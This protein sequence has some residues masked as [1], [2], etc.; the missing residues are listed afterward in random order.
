MKVLLY[1]EAENLIKESGLGRAIEHQKLALKSAKVSYTTDPNDSYDLAHINTY[2]LNSIRI[3][4]LCKREGKPVV[5][6]AHSTKEDFE[7]SFIGSN[8]A[9]PFFKEWLKYAYQ[10]G[11]II[12]TPSAYS[13][14]LL[15]SYHIKKEIKVVSNGIDLNHYQRSLIDP[16]AFRQKYGLT[17][18]QPVVVSVGLWI[19]RKGILDFLA[20][21]KRMPEITFFWFGRTEEQLV[22]F[23]IREAIKH[24]PANVVMPGYVQPEE[25][26][27]AYVGA[28]LFLFPTY[29]ETEGIVLLEAM[30][31]KTPAIVRD[32]PIYEEWLPADKTVL[33]AKNLDEFEKAIR[34]GL[35]HNQSQ[36][37]VQAYDEVLPLALPHIGQQLKAIYQRLL[38]QQKQK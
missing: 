9:A 32:I 26:R 30:A 6:H 20:L 28:D 4:K 25:L 35:T 19:K 5:M 36:M 12:V 11:D 13:R 31:L 27:E 24:K 7:N 23:K 18:T 14:E 22:P 15:L 17:Q 8:L 16:T 34:F 33:K 3:A 29:E 10:R 38:D 21:A 2:F 1:S 37:V